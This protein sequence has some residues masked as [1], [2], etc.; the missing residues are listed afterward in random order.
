MTRLTK[1]GQ[2]VAAIQDTDRQRLQ[3]TDRVSQHFISELRRKQPRQRRLP[4]LIAAAVVGITSIIAIV[5][6][7]HRPSPVVFTVAPRLTVGQ[8]IVAPKDHSIPLSFSDGSEL[9]LTSGTQAN[10]QEL[11]AQGARITVEHGKAQVSVVH[12]PKTHFELLAGPYQVAVTG[13][14]FELEWLPERERF[15]LW[16]KEGSVL[17]TANSSTH[18]AVKM[19]AS[20]RLVI[21]RGNWQLSPTKDN[22][23]T[24]LVNAPTHEPILFENARVPAPAESASTR[25]PVAVATTTTLSSVPSTPPDWK[26]LGK[27]G[28]YDLAYARAE[29]LNIATLAQNQSVQSLLTLAE[30]C[31]FAGHGS[32]AMLVLTKLRQRFTNTDEAAIAAFQLGRLSSSGQQAATWFRNYLRERPNGTLAREA[33]GRLLEALDRSGDRTGAI[34]AARVYLD[35]YPAG[36]HAA[37][38]RRILG[39]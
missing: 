28:K 20:E 31:R 33:S 27:L 35:R 26:K 21:E 11:T 18:A 10:V 32:E 9:I 16:L 14:K 19:A 2:R 4:L 22:G 23:E 12:R 36:P 13:T 6:V 29:E 30:V 5:V 39:S 25:L 37:F 38:A 3:L 15:D 1:L 24:L 17:V 8:S 7:T 34:T